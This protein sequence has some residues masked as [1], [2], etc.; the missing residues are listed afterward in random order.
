MITS[1]LTDMYLNLPEE[2]RIKI[3]SFLPITQT[4]EI[5]ENKLENKDVLFKLISDEVKQYQ[6]NV[7][8]NLLLSQCFSCENELTP[9]RIINVCSYCKFNFQNKDMYPVYCFQCYPLKNPRDFIFQNCK[10][11]QHF[12]AVLGI[13]DYS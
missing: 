11:C 7:F 12:S 4:K 2:V 3:F 8:R 9:Q 13:T 6:K 1:Y 10:L 5:L